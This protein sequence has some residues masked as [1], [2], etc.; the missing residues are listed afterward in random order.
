MLQCFRSAGTYCFREAFPRTYNFARSSVKIAWISIVPS[1]WDPRL[2]ILL[3]LLLR[4]VRLIRLIRCWLTALLGAGASGDAR[5]R[6]GGL[7]RWRRLLCWHSLTIGLNGVHARW[8]LKAL[9]SLSARESIS[10]RSGLGWRSMLCLLRVSVEAWILRSWWLL[11]GW[12]PLKLCRR[13]RMSVVD[14]RL[15]ASGRKLLRIATVQS[16][17]A[18]RSNVAL[19]SLSC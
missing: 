16:V 18:I 10:I 15:I 5:R 4:L 6:C 1:R 9:C 8:R 13:I 3:L 19:K 14:G 2:L 11:H 12:L 17:N 7:W